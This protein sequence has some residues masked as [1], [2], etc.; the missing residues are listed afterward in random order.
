[1]WSCI[2]YAAASTVSFN[3]NQLYRQRSQVQQQVAPPSSTD[4]ST[5]GAPSFY[6]LSG[7]PQS[8][9]APPSGHILLQQRDHQAPPASPVR[10]AVYNS[11]HCLIE[12]A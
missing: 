6:P 3:S 9:G 5:V 1:M 12:C 7:T 2:K 11:I 8:I 10:N 4:N